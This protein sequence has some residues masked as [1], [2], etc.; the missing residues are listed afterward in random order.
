LSCQEQSAHI[1]QVV[2]RF[3]ERIGAAGYCPIREIR[4]VIT[5]SRR[6]KP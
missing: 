1:R 5:I 3:R 6:F 4:R 2:E